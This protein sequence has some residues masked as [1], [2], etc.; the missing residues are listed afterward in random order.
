[1]VIPKALMRAWPE[2]ILALALSACLPQA[3]RQAFASPAAVQ[4]ERT[5][6]IAFHRMEIGFLEQGSYTTNVL[7]DLKLP[8]GVMWR[9][10]DFSGDS[11]S[12]LFTV[13]SIPDIAWRVSPSG[14]SRIT[15]F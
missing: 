6:T 2:L 9:L 13:D 11:Y 4:A 7:V 8:R 14:V 5:A 1:M 3:T 15:T 10:E 12:L